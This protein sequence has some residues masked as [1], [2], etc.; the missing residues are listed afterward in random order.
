MG[1]TLMRFI[2]A[3]FS[4]HVIGLKR[5]YRCF[6]DSFYNSAF[7]MFNFFRRNILYNHL[8]QYERL[9][10]FFLDRLLTVLHSKV[11]KTN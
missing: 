3:R 2:E 5:E 6:V 10:Q 1:T 9:T 7:E 11:G 4:I 8:L